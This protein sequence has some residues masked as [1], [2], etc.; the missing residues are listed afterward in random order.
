MNYETDRRSHNFIEL[1]QNKA[2]Q[3]QN[4][5]LF[6]SGIVSIMHDFKEFSVKFKKI[7]KSFTVF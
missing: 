2:D 3:L 1:H 7:I 5:Q 6:L 4:M